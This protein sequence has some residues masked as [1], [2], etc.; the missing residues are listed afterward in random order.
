MAG[1]P[2]I[3]RMIGPGVPKIQVVMSDELERKLRQEIAH[4][5]GGRKGDLSRAVV[6][7]VELWL[8]KGR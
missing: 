5:Y 1:Y 8:K 3:L 6:E 4:R 7:A 2:L